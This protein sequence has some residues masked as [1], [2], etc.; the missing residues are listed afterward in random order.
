M[1]VRQAIIAGILAVV[2][3]TICSTALAQTFVPIRTDTRQ[4]PSISAKIY[5]LDATGMPQSLSANDVAVTENGT[6]ATA[7][8]TCE[9]SN[10]GRNL[11]LVVAIDASA[12]TSLGNPSSMDLMKNAARGV[13]QLLTATSDEIGLLTIDAQANL[14]YGLSTDRAT[15]TSVVDNVRTSAGVNFNNGLMDQP[16]G[17]LTHL[18]NAR[19]N[20]ALLILTDGAPSFDIVASI[21]IARTFGIRVYVV[22]MNNTASDQLK[23][24]ADS[25]GGAWA[26]NVSTIEDATAFAR[27]FLADAK[28]F[29]SCNV[30]WTSTT[31]CVTLRKVNFTVGTTNRSLSYTLPTSALG[32]LEA[33]TLGL[34]FGQPSAGNVVSRTVSLSARNEDVIITNITISNTRF[35]LVSSP[36]LPLTIRRGQSQQLNVQYSASSTDGQYGQMS[37]TSATCDL[38]I[39]S[40][41]GGSPFVGAE[42]RLVRPNGGESFVAGSDT[43][44]EW[45]NVLPQDVV[46]LEFSSDGGNVWKPLAESANGLSYTWKPGP[47]VSDNCR[48]RV[49]RTV[50]DPDN[51]VELKG[52]DQPLYAAVFTEDGQKV[53]TGGHDGTVR[54]WNAFN[55][56]QDRLVGVHGNWVWA[57]AVMPN[58]TNVASASFDGSVRVWDYT[59]GNRIATIPM[60]GEAFSVAFSPDG[61]RLFIGSRRSI[62]VVSTTTWSTE[63]VKV[64]TTGPVYDIDMAANG[65]VIAVAEGT[66]A[67]I[68][69]ASTLEV[70][71]TLESGGRSGEIYSIA[72]NNAATRVATGGTD[73]IVATFNAATGTQIGTAQAVIAPILG[74]DYSPDGTGLLSS[75]GDGTVKIYDAN[76]LA[77]Q[78]SLAGH[79]GQ[80]FSAVYSPNGKRVASASLDF[81]ARVWTLD[82]IGSISDASDQNFRIL[83]ATATA[84]S[85]DMGNVALGSGTDKVANAVTAVGSA[86]LKIIGASFVSG[87]VTDFGLVTTTLPDQ[88]TAGSPL[89]LDISFVPTQLGPRSADVDVVTGTGTVRVR[90]TGNGVNPTFVAPIVVDYGR[91]V[92][93][94]AIVDTVITFRV[95]ST[96]T[97]PVTVTT[98]TLTGP[99]SSQFSIQA[100]GGNFTV[101]P[102]Q[103]KQLQ[104][105]FEP[106]DFGRFAA[107]LVLD[108]QGGAPFRVRL[109]GEGTGDGRIATTATI[110]FP[111]DRCAD[112]TSTQTITVSNY[113]NTQ[114]QVFSAGV[115]GAN[116]SEFTVTAPSAYPI[117]IDPTKQITLNVTF[118]PT[119]N[120][121]KDAKVVISSSAVNAVNGRSVVPISARRDSVGFELSRP[122]VNFNNI[123]EGQESIE[124]LLLLNT[125]TVALRWPK[126]SI[127]VGQFRIENITPEVTQPGQQSDMTIRF[128]GGTAGTVY[129]ETYTFVDSVCGTAEPL[130]M[131]ATVK[132]YIGADLR[133]ARV[134]AAIGQEIDVPIYISNKVNFDRTSVTQLDARLLVNGTILTPTGSTP[135][136]T[137]RSDGMREIAVMIPIP[138]TDSLATT[139]RFR[140]SWGNDTSS[141]IHIDSLILTD[142][143]QIR[144]HDGEV[145]ITDICREGG[146]RLIELTQ[147]AAGIRV[148]PLPATGSTTAV[149]TTVEAGRTSVDLVDLTGRVVRTVADRVMQGGSWFIP[150]D[151]TT[152]PNGSYFLILTTPSQRIVERIE[153][154]R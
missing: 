6:Q 153:V 139:L 47:T 74:L 152:I 81:T 4:Y 80:I 50:V 33:S 133:I 63:T 44:I 69:N 135:L 110:L 29:P 88:I 57:L 150:L 146:P 21:G 141:V 98:T 108:I 83:G 15:Y 5:A 46:R 140:T 16:M 82:G 17:G 90:V 147:Q 142:T 129:D 73:Y 66:T 72:L 31:S 138:T 116:A 119:Q 109:Y 58:T 105:R 12:S 112:P 65:T 51:I 37:F 136:G 114:L 14:L 2:S 36:S 92:A 122:T 42:L 144:T 121:P 154:V 89:S 125:G 103:Q 38:P 27:G 45:T 113:G 41:R 54:L 149:V 11:S 107:D 79:E 34:H 23:R 1:R 75:G 70:S 24:L 118:N 106:T 77:L 48:I 130:R 49:S 86:P 127:V 96:A 120:G 131:I 117:Q 102:G 87:D 93:N 137:F 13:T 20:R 60:D 32:V 3:I 97:Q 132:S 40:L 61:R 128:L 76:T 84:T 43:I 101:A 104:V 151:L 25:S 85:I 22:C 148:A 68:R 134:N 53:I 111:T 9:P 71:A 64:V 123:N 124:R 67:T 8:T 145:L 56:T 35:S 52:S 30:S 126:T 28:N 26:D 95:P 39:I 62:T 94:Q 18:Q 59:T 10:A 91:R 19:N 143:L 78:S 100:G 55:G 7:T 115:E 99:Q